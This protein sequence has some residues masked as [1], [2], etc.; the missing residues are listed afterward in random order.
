MSIII[1]PRRP[2]RGIQSLSP[3]VLAYI[4]DD[5]SSIES[6]CG[7]TASFI[8]VP[9]LPYLGRVC[10][11]WHNIIEQHPALSTS[12]VAYIDQSHDTPESIQASPAGTRLRRS[13]NL[14]ISIYLVRKVRCPPAL[15]IE[16]RERSVVR[17]FLAALTIHAPRIKSLVIQADSA[18]TLPAVS[19]LLDHRQFPQL[20][21]LVLRC[22]GDDSMLMHPKRDGPRP[23]Y[24]FDGIYPPSSVTV[25]CVDGMNLMSLLHHERADEVLGSLV[26]VTTFAINNLT[27]RVDR[28]AEHIIWKLFDVF[29]SLSHLNRIEFDYFDMPEPTVV[30]PPCQPVLPL[31]IQKLCIE[32]TNTSSLK[33]ILD[34]ISPD[35][36]VLDNCFFTSP[37]KLPDCAR[38]TIVRMAPS[39][40]NL[41]ASLS[42]WNGLYLEI[43]SSTQFDDDFIRELEREHG[44]STYNR[45]LFS[46]LRHLRISDCP[47][48]SPKALL[49]LF[50]KRDLP[51]NATF[52]SIIQGGGLAV[53][54]MLERLEILGTSPKLGA[55]LMEQV[56]KIARRGVWQTEP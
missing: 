8:E 44:E 19:I 5:A 46:N 4:L 36:L 24:I 22:N 12:I 1:P 25:L 39:Y 16:R 52:F 31:P 18:S 41:P 23:Q 6:D 28:F 13:R 29:A 49:D 43:R 37:L 51:K 34:C 11:P 45:I 35:D 47:K 27:W 7:G 26:N 15:D 10:R 38:L 56:L 3:A 32:R 9:M 42:V 17:A 50:E 20:R 55:A 53:A 48:F 14:P 2:A 54:N 30:P 33:Y 40:S 21:R